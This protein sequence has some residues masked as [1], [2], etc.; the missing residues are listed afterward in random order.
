MKEIIIAAIKSMSG[1]GGSIL[2]GI[3][4]TKVFA[5]SLGPVG[6][7]IY[8][9]LKNFF[10]IGT[11]ISTFSGQ[12]ALVQGVA[13]REGEDANTFASTALT[14]FLI[15]AFT[16]AFIVFCFSGQL[17]SSILPETVEDGDLVLKGMALAFLFS[18]LSCYMAGLLNGFRKIG[19]L[20]LQRVFS[21]GVVAIMAWPVS[22]LVS[23][24]FLS[25]FTLLFLASSLTSLCYGLFVL[26]H[27]MSLPGNYFRPAFHLPEARSFLSVSGALFIN[28]F[29]SP[30]SELILR[31]AIFSVIGVEFAGYFDVAWSLSMVYVTLIMT[32]LSTYYMPK[33]SEASDENKRQQLMSNMLRFI[34]TTILPVIV[35]V[36]ILKPFVISLLYSDAFLPA[37]GMIS[38]MLI[39][40]FL[41]ATAFVFS[42]PLL[43]YA[44]MKSFLW[45]QLIWRGMATVLSLC[46]IYFFHSLEMVGVSFLISYATYLIYFFFLA[47]K[48]YGFAVDSKNFRDWLIALAIILTT[49]VLFWN[50]M[51]VNWL[52]AFIC[53]LSSCIASWSFLFSHE[54][55]KVLSF[56][57]SRL[58]R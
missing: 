6:I 24:G 14:F 7:G 15:A 52:L 34:Y 22:I 25:S 56:V 11:L 18:S 51:E 47:R 8:S 46:S 55:Q 50:A 20:A 28:A 49:S 48:K 35:A 4:T 9:L 19:A 17:A 21:A 33:L 29:L 13:S 3:I 39:G 32:S 53:L 57:H 40:D 43:S 23:Q 38:W 30:G 42:M 41:K 31:M 26:K 5:V 58:S 12:T 27:K 36:I 44:H 2:F 45:T 1:S 37:I 16:T 10:R 54:Q